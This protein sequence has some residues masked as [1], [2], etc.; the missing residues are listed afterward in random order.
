VVIVAL[1]AA[2]ISVP[3][4]VS[5]PSVGQF[6]A[7]FFIGP[8]VAAVA[9]LAWWLFASRLRWRDRLLGAGAF[10][11]AGV[12]VFL[13]GDESVQLVL[14]AY[15]LPLVTS[16]WV[17]WLLGTQFLAWPARRLG[18]LAVLLLGWGVW[19][20]VRAGVD[21]AFSPEFHWR[22]TPTAEDRLLAQLHDRP[23]PAAAYDEVVTLQPG[24]WPGFRGPRRDGRLKDVRIGTDWATPHPPRKVWRHDVGPGWGS[25]AVVGH[26]LY[27]QEQRGDVELVVCYDADKGDELWAHADTVRFKEKVSGAGPRAT[28]TFDDSKV[29]ALG[30]GGVLNCLDAATGKVV[31][32]KD[33]T[34]VSGAKAPEWGFASS[35]LVWH[36]LVT[37]VAGSPEGKT[38]LAYDARSG[39]PAWQAGEGQHSYCS[40][41]PAT[42]GGVEQILV[43]GDAGL[44]AYDPTE[45]KVLW[46]HDCPSEQSLPR[47]VQPVLVGDADVLLGTGFGSERRLRVREAETAE[48][49]A[50]KA[51]KA[52]YN[53]RVVHDGHVYGF[54]VNMFTCLGLDDGKARWRGGRYG[55]GQVLLLEEQGLLLILSEKGEVALV[56]ADPARHRELGRFK[57]IEGKTWNHPVLAHGRLFVRNGEEAA[58]YELPADS[59]AAAPGE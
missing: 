17:L 1:Q 3:L 13:L 49:W 25:F 40:P 30:G 56:A 32:S 5:S 29:Y 2:V 9:L 36:G 31:W 48:V 54:D 45:G 55:N 38:L 12:A 42:I 39:K 33:I 58:C 53:D 52:Y 22:W 50:S 11:A 43:A 28:P 18:L 14:T 41:Q 47:A 44:T 6:M 7:A 20:L 27:T 57:A 26:R 34:E 51:L 10:L 16:A 23:A 15:A 35:P 59:A 19:L 21:G 24:D 37:V 4:W 8:L 46:R